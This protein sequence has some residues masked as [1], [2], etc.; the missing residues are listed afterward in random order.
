MKTTT[1]T[2]FAT[3][4]NDQIFAAYVRMVAGKK[5]DFPINLIKKTIKQDAALLTTDEMRTLLE[6]SIVQK[7]I[8]E[9]PVTAKVKTAKAPKEKAEKEVVQLVSI[10]NLE[11]GDVI[12]Y[13]SSKKPYIISDKKDEV[14]LLF[15]KTQVFESKKDFEVVLVKKGAGSLPVSFGDPELDELLTLALEDLETRKS[16]T[17]EVKPVAEKVEK[18]ISVKKEK[19]A[20]IEAIAAE[21]SNILIVTPAPVRW[22]APAEEDQEFYAQS[23]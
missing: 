2:N 23:N 20:K 21:S 4:S 11:T 12:R 14:R 19:K 5:V 3:M 15:S 8:D 10:T 18:P 7:M 1:I 6:E 16:K 17:P 9:T 22:E 13:K